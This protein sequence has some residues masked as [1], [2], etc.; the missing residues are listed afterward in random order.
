MRVAAAEEK[1][2]E[3]REASKMRRSG[4]LYSLRNVVAVSVGSA[5]WSCLPA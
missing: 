2:K 3:E 4:E 5:G 1:D